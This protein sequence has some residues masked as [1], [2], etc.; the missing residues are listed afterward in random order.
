[1]TFSDIREIETL[2]N[3]KS[4][5]RERTNM[6]IFEL[7]D[8]EKFFNPL[9]SQNRR[10]YYE[11]IIS[12][13]ER[14]R[15]VPVLYDS[16]ARNCVA[17]YLKNSKYVFQDE[18]G[19]EQEQQAPERSASAIMAY[20]RECGWV[21]PRE[22]GR[23]GE[24]VANVSVSCRRII[25][26]FRKM[27]EKGNE[28][29]LSNHIFSMY[30]ILKASFEEDSAR[31]ERPYSTILKPLTDHVEELKNELLDL[32]DSIANIMRMVMELQ[33]AN[34]VGKFLMKDEL[35]DKF[36]N[37]YFFIKNNGLIPSQL[38]FIRNKL[39]VIEQGQIFEKMVEECAAVQQL[40]RGEAREKVGAVLAGLSYFLS[41]E[42]EENMELIDTRINTYYNLA[43]I[44]MML[45]M[46]NGVNMESLLDG[47]LNALKGMDNEERQQALNKAAECIRISSQK[48]IGRKSYERRKRRE[49]DHSDI[50]LP[51][52]DISQ[53]EKE[54]L[55]QAVM[56]G[57]KNRFS[58]ECTRRFLD[59][60]MAGR[61]EL[62]LREQRVADRE[63]AML[64]AA[65]VM[66]S[67]IEEF[68]YTVE[69][70]EDYVET[71][72]ARMTNMKI[73]KR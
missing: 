36:F 65:S 22:I 52:C 19:G 16:D 70:K 4:K 44:R 3:R 35:L 67:G 38:S 6:D 62:E 32:K 56:S 5:L 26:F 51:L 66:Y 71:D 11:C 12:L 10:I 40:E 43:N 14:S 60:R 9:S 34:S 46:G 59:E 29:A 25:E 8:N 57:T 47:F 27:C 21:T 68:P 45:V 54:Q 39:R 41:V 53:E 18:Q 72:I 64:F 33:D 49:R 48:Y 28:G 24:N 30:E 15:E 50:G 58:I 73:K 31:A 42:Y 23:N 13:I 69:L 55:T 61:K 17:I 20:L 1:M 37:D 63:E 7:V 2:D